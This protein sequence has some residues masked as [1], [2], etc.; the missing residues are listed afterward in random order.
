MLK[1]NDTLVALWV[2]GVKREALDAMIDSTLRVRGV[3][4]LDSPESPLLLTPGGSFVQTV[5]PARGNLQTEPISSL[6]TAIRNAVVPHRLRIAGVVTFCDDKIIFVQDDSGSARVQLVRNASVHPGDLIEATGF[7]EEFNGVP[8]LADARVGKL[9]AELSGIRSGNFELKPQQ[10]DLNAPVRE[11][12]NQALVRVKAFLLAQKDFENG[13]TLEVQS[14]Q[15]VW[16]AVLSGEAKMPPLAIGS[17]LELTGVCVLE[18]VPSAGTPHPGW[19]SSTIGAARLLLREPTDVTVLKGPPWWNWKKAVALITVLVV[20]LSATLLRVDLMRRRFAKQETARLAFARQ[21]LENQESERRRIAANLHDTLGQNL[22]A[23][24]N[25]THLALQSADDSTLQKR[26]EDI[27]GTV[28]NAIE[29][30]RQITHDLRPYQLDRLGLSQSIRALVRKVAESCPVELASHVDEIDG[31]FPKDSEINIYRIVQ[32]GI[33]NVV[34]HSEATE[35]AVVL[36]S[37]P[38]AVTISIRDNGRGLAPGQIL[39]EGSAGGFGLSGIRERARILNGRVEVES[40]SGGGFNL[41]VEIPVAA[42]Q[43]QAEKHAIETEVA[44]S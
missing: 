6:K 41:K 11:L 25:Q 22:L 17:L 32:E 14:G 15:R 37:Q 12:P 43:P 3:M 10:L 39:S 30:V 1:R 20:M 24:K 13:Q 16:E 18:L 44:H 28:L 36:K 26:L 38:G 42:I 7:P 2:A 19:E 21:L 33:N 4:S 40:A 8:V 34:K 9:S 29:E 27:S 23:I 35:A 5:L 31:L